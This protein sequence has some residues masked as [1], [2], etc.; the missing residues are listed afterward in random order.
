MVLVCK[1]CSKSFSSK[2]SLQRHYD[3]KFKCIGAENIFCLKELS[4]M[5]ILSYPELSKKKISYNLKKNTDK[6]QINRNVC[7]YCNRVFA[8]K[9]GLSKH[10]NTL[11][12]KKIPTQN[13]KEILK[14]CNNKT[15][16]ELRTYDDSLNSSTNHITNNITNILYNNTNNTINTQN[17][18]QTQNNINITINPF[19]KENLESVSEKTMMRILNKAFCAFPAALEEIFFKI[20]E[21]RNFYLPNK[22][23]RK[24]I[25][26]FDGSRCVYEKKDDFNYKVKNN[27]MDVLEDWFEICKDK[28]MIRRENLIS[29]MFEE[30]GKGKL[31]ETQ[32]NEI[33]KFLLTYSNDIKEFVDNQVNKLRKKRKAKIKIS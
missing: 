21:N 13:K 8:Y 9:S 29:R 1:R 14:M 22:S 26:Y 6:K 27:V 16:E 28:F 15:I 18:I 2:Q 31:D 33:E 32:D 7:K 12:C 25:S 10:I 3:R 19:G 30:Y 23:E 24:Y 11:V 17:N 20:P 4:K 5:V